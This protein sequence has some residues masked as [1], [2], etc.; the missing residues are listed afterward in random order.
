MNTTPKPKRWSV[1]KADYVRANAAQV[2]YIAVLER[3]RADL[4]DAIER[5]QGASNRWAAAWS[6]LAFVIGLALGA[7]LL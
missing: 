6:A 2:D 4:T 7:W 1:K 3:Q 5:E